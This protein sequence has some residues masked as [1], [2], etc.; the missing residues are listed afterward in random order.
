MRP[1]LN[2]LVV[3]LAMLL[4]G[5]G[6]AGE[7]A[8]FDAVAELPPARVM[9]TGEAAMPEVLRFA[10]Q[11]EPEGAGR[12]EVIRTTTRRGTGPARRAGGHTRHA[13]QAPAGPPL[14][15]LPCIQG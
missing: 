13:R 6:Q 5:I 11:A 8:L 4:P 3:C 10:F 15:W 2:L 7:R 1:S 9:C 14:L 12:P